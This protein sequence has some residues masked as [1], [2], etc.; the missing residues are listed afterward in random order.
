MDSPSHK[1]TRYGTNNKS[2]DWRA[3]YQI[4]VNEHTVYRVLTIW[5]TAQSVKMKVFY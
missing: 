3:G 1:S 4:S 5:Y 2:E